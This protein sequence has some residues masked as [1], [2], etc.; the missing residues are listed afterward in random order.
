MYEKDVILNDWE[1]R[2]G[3]EWIR[4]SY[5]IIWGKK[6]KISTLQHVTKS[7]LQINK[8]LD[9]NNWENVYWNK[10]QCRYTS[11]GEARKRPKLSEKIYEEIWI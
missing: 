3:T 5:L 6:R 9:I 7:P 11:L 10:S 2:A 1:I 4:E 8:G